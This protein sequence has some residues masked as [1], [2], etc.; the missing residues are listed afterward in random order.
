MIYQDN[1]VGNK[2]ISIFFPFLIFWPLFFLL[3]DDPTLMRNESLM[4][5]VQIEREMTS[6]I[7]SQSLFGLQSH[8]SG[9]IIQLINSIRATALPQNQPFKHQQ[10]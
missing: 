5:G 6:V 3:E 9:N 4:V 7:K 1:E 2:D 10:G 8:L